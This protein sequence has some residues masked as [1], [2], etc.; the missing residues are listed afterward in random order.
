MK[1][2]LY[3]YAILVM[4]LFCGGCKDDN[5]TVGEPR[6]DCGYSAENPIAFD[7][8]DEKDDVLGHRV[9]VH[10]NI[11]WQIAVEENDWLDV[12]PAQGWD[13]GRFY[14][15][16]ERNTSIYK[17]SLTLTV[18]DGKGAEV[19]TIPVVQAGAVRYL[20]VLSD[21]IIELEG[22]DDYG[23]AV[24]SNVTWNAE[25]VDEA[26]ASWLTLKGVDLENGR[27]GIGVAPLHSGLRE[28][29]IRLF[30][31]DADT[32]LEDVFVKVVQT[33]TLTL[34]D[35]STIDELAD[36]EDVKLENVSFVVPLGTLY[37]APTLA[38]NHCDLTIRDCKGN[39]FTVRT[40]DSD[41]FRHEQNIVAGNYNITGYIDRTTDAK[42]PAIRLRSAS[43][44]VKVQSE[45]Y[46]AIAEWYGD[47]SA[48]TTTGW[49][50]AT[51]SGVARYGVAIADADKKASFARKD[52]TQPYSNDN[53]YWGPSL[54]AWNGDKQY[55]E[56]EVSTADATGDIYLSL[57]Q[58][59]MKSS[60]L[61]YKV[62]W[63]A[64]GT[65]WT[66]CG[67]VLTMRSTAQFSSSN[68]NFLGTY[69]VKAAG[70]QG[71][72]KVLF[73][74]SKASNKRADGSKSAISSAGPNYMCYFGV[75]EL[76]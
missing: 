30:D 13:D 14:V 22:A 33:G 12:Y 64:D 57:W 18:T 31:V 3:F 70:A 11:G 35:F 66:D 38:N 23:I 76:K 75:Y 60:A 54:K 4:G 28:A 17:R 58:I 65:T 2:V 52:C 25:L 45:S 27:L 44:L 36:G 47:K 72:A 51:G 48:I 41:T 5:E 55:Y 42:V 73:R 40:T 56:F 20:R 68:E 8:G 67:A 61:E 49:Q 19:Q 15:K 29:K 39:T 53:T 1:K 21:V 6:F 37:N 63:S 16:A 9:V 10:S 7:D 59:S 43:D 62:E 46:R 50:V 34:A 32:T 26:A 24:N 71:H 74:V 69:S